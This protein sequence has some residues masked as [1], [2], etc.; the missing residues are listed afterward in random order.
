MLKNMKIYQRLILGFGIMLI[1][2]VALIIAGIRSASR[3]ND[4][5]AEE[6]KTNSKRKELA[7]DML[8]RIRE[9][10]LSLWIM[11]AD[12]ESGTIESHRT[13]IQTLRERYDSTFADY[14][15]LLSAGDFKRLRIVDNI[16]T[17]QKDAREQ[18]DKVLQMMTE[19]KVA[20]GVN[21]MTTTAIPKVAEWLGEIYRLLDYEK[22][23]SDQ[24]AEE[25]AFIYRKTRISL[26]ILG[27]FSIV[28]GIVIAVL[29]TNSITS[30]LKVVTSLIQTRNTSIDISAYK[31][32]T[33]EFN[34]MIQS[35]HKEVSE[36]LKQEE[37]LAKYRDRLEEIVNQRTS[38]L[39]NIISE[40]KETVNIIVSSS[41]QILS[42][43]TQV[44][45]GTAETATAINETTTT[46][47]E[48][49]Q[50]T[51]L[52]ALKANKV[53]ENAQSVAK[54][55]QDGQ[56]SVQETINAMNRIREQMDLIAQT[57]VRLSEQSQSIGGIIASVT[58]IAD[59]SN[60]L[61]VNAAIEAAKAGE[62]GRGFAVVAQ[63][64]KNMAGQSKQ[65]TL[66]VRNILNDIQ[67][68][69]GAA[70]MATEQGTKAVEGGV[71]QSV[72]SGEAIRLL[73]DS[74]NEAVQA[75]T[76]IVASSN[77]QVVGMDQISTAMQNINQAGTEAAVSMTQ[78][79]RSAKNLYE[80]GQKLKEVIEKINM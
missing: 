50:A 69:T 39:K 30:P 78:T 53:A 27:G 16:K 6:V 51:K 63:E 35:F 7:N 58:D 24:A 31:D 13:K 23:E 65:A 45:S 17:L 12:R 21:S 56:D 55:S 20:E 72:Q 70:V 60:L 34:I 76:Q 10:S 40:V 74:S 44:A 66:Q 49:L 42:A 52:S 64:I 79:E 19:G 73:A 11:V 46:V 26:F 4:I 36:R 62:Y 5:L 68:V 28:I 59:Q 48:V 80:L 22:I 25:A 2:I 71:K 57:V 47:E 77:Q 32:G 33:S 41:S 67:K 61:A 29:L 15:S 1:V 75:A 43:T 9:V 18:N 3:V 8:D 38:E 54:I 37:E 14:E